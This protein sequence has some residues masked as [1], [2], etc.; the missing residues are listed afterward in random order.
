MY[1][2]FS[3][4]LY[5]DRHIQTN[6]KKKIGYLSRCF[7]EMKCVTQGKM[8]VRGRFYFAHFILIVML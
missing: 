3:L 6:N 1:H 5:T 8:C 4:K 7:F 2:I